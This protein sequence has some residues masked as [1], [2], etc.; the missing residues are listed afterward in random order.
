M[1]G[2]LGETLVPA[3]SRYLPRDGQGRTLSRKEAVS[4]PEQGFGD[5]T[6]LAQT[7]TVH[8]RLDGAVALRDSAFRVSYDNTTG[9]R[10]GHR[11][12]LGERY[13]E[14]LSVVDRG[15]GTADIRVQPVLRQSYADNTPVILDRPVCRMHFA[16]ENEGYLPFDTSPVASVTVNFREATP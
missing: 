14:V 10:P 4:V 9:L 8:A 13:H 2:T 7:D 16:D 15:D 3:W 5:N 12:G 6:G 11:V 1:Q